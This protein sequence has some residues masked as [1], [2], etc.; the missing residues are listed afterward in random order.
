MNDRQLI[1][2]ILFFCPFMS[3]VGYIFFVMDSKLTMF[4]VILSPYG[5]DCK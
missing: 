5:N 2:D 1:T 4:E 3:S